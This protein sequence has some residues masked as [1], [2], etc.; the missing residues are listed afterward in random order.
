M[1]AVHHHDWNEKHTGVR[2][3][4]EDWPWG[5]G[6][7][8]AAAS[9]GASQAAGRVSERFPR[10]RGS[11]ST[12]LLHSS[13]DLLSDLQ[14]EFCYPCGLHPPQNLKKEKNQAFPS[15]LFPS[16]VCEHEV[17][18]VLDTAPALVPQGL[19]LQTRNQNS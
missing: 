19:P 8:R 6:P 4:E 7:R 9:C 11:V 2:E 18:T 5:A 1:I 14:N 12:Y 15:E 3:S 13:L 10:A 17:L 16:Q